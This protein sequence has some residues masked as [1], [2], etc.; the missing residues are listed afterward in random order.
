MT[1]ATTHPVLTPDE[2]ADLLS[3][4]A[5]AD[6]SGYAPSDIGWTPTYDLNRAAAEG[7]R[8]KAGKAAAEFDFSSEE[9][10]KFER[11]QVHAACMAQSHAYANR[12]VGSV[13]V[14]PDD[15]GLDPVIANVN[16]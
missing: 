12:V 8:W 10:S 9:R 2:V 3:M 4:F 5:V 13:R 15:V 14:V 6:A 1:A 11:S 16:S 7:W